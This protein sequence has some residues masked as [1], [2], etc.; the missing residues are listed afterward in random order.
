MTCK[1]KL[2]QT[3]R[4]VENFPKP[5]ISFKDISPV[6]LNP[7]L[8]YECV[9]EMAAPWKNKGINRVMGIESRGFIFGP[10]LARELN[11]GFVIVRKAGKLPPQ[12]SSISYTLE[13]GEAIIEI[14]VDVLKPG[15]KVLVH[16]DLLATG[17][18]AAA[19]ARLAQMQGAEIAGFS[20]LSELDFL[21]GRE[22]LSLFSGDIRS[23]LNF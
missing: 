23:I 1:E 14:P 20:F 17:G 19:A 10:M 2:L 9:Q 21:E 16:D 11:A 8:V 3:I 15:D 5:G 22:K 4:V 13:Y 6:L 18:T 7:E 12:T